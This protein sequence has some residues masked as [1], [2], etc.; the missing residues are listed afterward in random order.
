[1]FF[2]RPMLNALLWL[3]SALG[4]QFWLAIIVFTILIRVVMTPLML[5]QQLSAKKM[6]DI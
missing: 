5:P 4:N 3:Y 6:Q 1:M 2:L